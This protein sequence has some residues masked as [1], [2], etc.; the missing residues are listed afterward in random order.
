MEEDIQFGYLETDE[1]NVEIEEVRILDQV[2]EIFIEGNNR[3]EYDD[4]IELQ[5][6]VWLSD[7]NTT[8]Q[9]IFNLAEKRQDQSKY[10]TLLAFFNVC[11]FGTQY[12]NDNAFQWYKKAA[13]IGDSLG[14]QE[15]GIFFQQG[16]GTE[17]NLEE[18]I[19]WFSKAADAGM[20]IA[21]YHLAR[22]YLRGD[23]V[24]MDKSRA[25]DFYE[26]SAEAGFD[27]AYA[28]IGWIHFNGDGVPQDQRI[29]LHQFQMLEEMGSIGGTTTV[30]FFHYHGFGTNTDK[31]EAVKA[32][33][34]CMR[35]GL[36][37][38][39]RHYEHIEEIFDRNQILRHF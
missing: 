32:Y 21:S 15:V 9:N 26:K 14:Q 11:G 34:R 22:K 7:K 31:H 28:A 35:S 16:I 12:N 24:E 18:A 10:W 39:S 30:A 1:S 29:A 2:R 19:K 4:F 23:G 38:Y 27:E 8:P 5:I 25:M 13:E 37:D 3:W 33:L 17:Q 6:Q 36:F 20:A